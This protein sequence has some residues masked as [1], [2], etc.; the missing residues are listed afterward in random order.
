MKN[1]A[2][3]LTGRRIVFVMVEKPIVAFS[4]VSGRVSD[5]N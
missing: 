5:A 3:I 1:D 2:A 4:S